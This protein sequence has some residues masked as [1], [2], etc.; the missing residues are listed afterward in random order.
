MP[1]VTLHLFLA[2]WPV[3]AL[4][5]VK[6]S[7]A[8]GLFGSAVESIGM[9]LQRFASPRAQSTGAVLIRFG[10]ALEA[11]CVDVPKFVENATGW[12]SKLAKLFGTAAIFLFVCALLFGARV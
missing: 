6:V 12:V 10:K 7:G 9:L 2:N 8:I 11:A 3:F 4:L 1:Q 5:I